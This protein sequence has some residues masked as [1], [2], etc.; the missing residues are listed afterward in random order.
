MPTF[1]FFLNILFIYFI[2]NIR[3]ILCI[4][5]GLDILARF[6]KGFYEKGKFN[7]DRASVIKN[8]LSKGFKIDLIIFLFIS[9]SV[10]FH[11]Y[12]WILLIVF[13]KVTNFSKQM[14]KIRDSFY[15][16]I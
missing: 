9:F 1:I 13:L 3:F 14:D 10:Y 8:Y 7:M 12:K 15:L 2:K 16:S 4:F 11:N 6:N 5:I